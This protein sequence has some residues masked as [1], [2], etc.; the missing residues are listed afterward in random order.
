MPVERLKAYGAPLDLAP[1]FFRA[2][3]R[4]WVNSGRV[5]DNELLAAIIRNDLGRVIALSRENSWPLVRDTMRWLWAF[6][7]ERWTPGTDFTELERLVGHLRGE[8]AELK[9]KIARLREE[10][11]T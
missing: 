2:E 5:P 8:N 3:L 10:W 6:H 11:E 9:A 4:A 1:Q 7:P